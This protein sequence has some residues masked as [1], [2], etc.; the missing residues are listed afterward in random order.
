[1]SE[2][3]SVCVY[4]GSSSG[5]DPA[6][7]NAARSLGHALAENGVQLVYGGGEVGLMGAV[8]DAAMERGGSVLGVIPK[9]LFTREVKH[10]GL[11]ELIETSSMHERKQIMADRS[12]AFVALPGGF[13]TLEELAEVTT[14]A[15]LGMHTKPIA[16]LDI[17]GFWAPFVEFIDGAIAAGFVKPANRA[18]ISVVN[19]P[20][21]V[22]PALDAYDV[23]YVDKWLKSAEKTGE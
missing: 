8:A 5:S 20:N 7:I 16:L 17:N 18:L 19:S 23:P 21:E 10:T 11:T 15:Q 2:L 12:D 13:G 1:M 14:W 4:C 3:S 6:Y 22:L 9:G